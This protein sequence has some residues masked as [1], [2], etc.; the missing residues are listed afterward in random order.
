MSAEDTAGVQTRAMTEAQHIEG[1]CKEPWT[2]IKKDV[3][4]QST[5]QER[6]QETQQ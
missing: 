5:I 1:E 4:E 6:L 3:K 2:I